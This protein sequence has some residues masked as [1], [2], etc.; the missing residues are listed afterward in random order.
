MAR[1]QRQLSDA[2]A[3][4]RLPGWGQETADID[5]P[6][7]R[8][9]LVPIPPEDFAGPSAL[10]VQMNGWAFPPRLPRRYEGR[11]WQ[12]IR[13]EASAVQRAFP[14]ARDRPTP[15]PAERLADWPSTA[16]PAPE[17]RAIVPLAPPPSN[18]WLSA[19][20]AIAWIAYRGSPEPENGPWDEWYGAER[21]LVAAAADGRVVVEGTPGTKESPEPGSFPEPI[22]SGVFAVPDIGFGILNNTLGLRPF[23]PNE[24]MMGAMFSFKGPFFHHI[25]IATEG[26][27]RAFPAAEPK[28][29]AAVEK[30]GTEAAPSGPLQAEVQHPAPK[31]R[32]GGRPERDDWPVFDQEMMR[33]LALDGGNLTLRAFKRAMKDWAAQNMD[34]APDDRTIE[35]RIDIRA[36]TD[37]F[38]PE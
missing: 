22:P 25:R 21:A 13:F 16:A 10:T 17:R 18:T 14:Q 32:A 28:A 19:D 36:P 30:L 34:P 29:E 11:W 27:R 7:L 12:G 37:V 23:H 20:A 8:D 26:V 9:T 24:P 1:A 2:V 6:P 38:A 33:R 5:R 31:R 35:R 3:A 4:R 15:E